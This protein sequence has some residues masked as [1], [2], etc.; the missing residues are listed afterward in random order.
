MKNDR[1]NDS[2]S[3]VC[4]QQTIKKH[5]PEEG[6][7]RMKPFK[8]RI[9]LNIA[10]AQII[11]VVLMSYS[12]LGQDLKT[13]IFSEANSAMKEA[14]KIKANVLAP[15]AFSEGLDL[16]QKA[17]ADYKK[18]KNLDD[19][20]R[21]LRLAT[22]RFQKAT[23]ATQLA[24]MI[25]GSAIQARNDAIAAEAPK[26]VSSLWQKSEE[27][28]ADAARTL[29]EGEMK[30]A[31]RKATEAESSFRAAELQAIKVNYLNEAYSL[32]K[33]ADKLEVEEYAPKTLQNAKKLVKE[34]EK[35]LSENRYDT[36]E[37]RDLAKQAKYEANHAIYLASLVKKMKDEKKTTEDLLLDSEVP[38][39]RI[40][41]PIDL[42]PS[43]DNGLQ[44]PTDDVIKVIQ[45]YQ[46][47]TSELN[48]SL[49]DANQQITLLRER[50]AELERLNAEL[51]KK[52]GG[53]ETEKSALEKRLE[54]QAKIRE[55]YAA[56]SNLFSPGE[57]IVLRDRND[58]IFRL[59]GLSFPVGK[60]TIDPKFYD[61]LTKIQQAIKLFPD[62]KLTIT[63]HTD[64]YGSDATNLTLSRDRSESVKNYLLENMNVDPAKIEAVGYGESKPIATNETEEGRAR[65]RRI[66]IVIHP[67]LGETL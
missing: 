57:A 5:Q 48:S 45:D 20:R 8:I 17:E 63:G 7:H 22:S 39:K 50:T 60:A 46:K 55:R 41:E 44:P 40:S 28:F 31:K 53:I 62:A 12:V 66:E 19:I 64:S 18:E 30:E 21:N 51:R 52:L 1:I 38:L 9:I 25:F 2:N 36:D 47:N 6:M 32:F 11:F 14:E 56:A 65:N 58:L 27:K 15:K 33:K 24:T 43:F 23:E 29:E 54:I 10:M 42:I 37:A 4:F 3:Q 34:A 16:Y 59:I 67:N 49:Y 35:Q 26:Y 13:A 61:Y